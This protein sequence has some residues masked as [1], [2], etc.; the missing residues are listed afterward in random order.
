MV[1]PISPDVVALHRSPEGIRYYESG[2][3]LPSLE[4]IAGWQSES[5]RA[6][7]DVGLKSI[8]NAVEDYWNR[9]VGNFRL[10]SIP[11]PTITTTSSR[12]LRPAAPPVRFSAV[13]YGLGNYA[14]T[15]IIPGLDPRIRLASIHELDPT[16]IS[17]EY[18]KRFRISTNPEGGGDENYDVC[19]IAGYHHTH[20]DLTIRALDRGVAAVVEKP[21]VTTREQLD[22]LTAALR[23]NGGRLYSCFQMRYNPLF[24][25]ARRDLLQGPGDPVH[26]TADVYEIPLPSRHWY[27]WPNSGSHLV[28]NGCHWLD[29]FLFMNDF[30]RPVRHTVSRMSNGDTVATVELINGACLLLHLTHLGSQRI[31]VQEYVAMRREDRTATVVNSSNYRAEDRYRILRKKRIN[32]MDVYRRMYREISRKVIA[33]EAGDSLKSIEITNTLMLDLEED[34]QRQLESQDSSLNRCDRR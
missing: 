7:A 23:R 34:L 3:S 6:I 31:G 24:E 28:S 14:K 20:A 21:V 9:P 5:G 1:R 8:L 15:Q 30:S 17:K 18:R 2:P 27:R 12:G 16:Q 26:I 33:G 10:L 19:L 4:E 25:L 22:G 13:L 32:K 11:E 29:H